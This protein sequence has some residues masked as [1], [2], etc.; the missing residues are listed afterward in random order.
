M[1]QSMMRAQ[2]GGCVRLRKDRRPAAGVGYPRWPFTDELLLMIG[3]ACVCVVPSSWSVQSAKPE[4]AVVEVGKLTQR[5]S[6]T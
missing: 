3:D 1:V 4:A 2:V 6:C 5:K